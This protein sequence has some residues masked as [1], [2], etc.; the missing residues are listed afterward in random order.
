MT[1]RKSSTKALKP[2]TAKEFDEKFD[3]GE[4]VSEH[5]QW[6]KAVRH[7]P[8]KVRRVNIDFPEW[9]I[10]ELDVKADRLGIARQSL[11]K[12]WVAEKLKAEK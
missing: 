10:R 1:Q 2:I 8:N 4:D 11:V 5:I 7:E 9:M 12:M 6:D 3:A